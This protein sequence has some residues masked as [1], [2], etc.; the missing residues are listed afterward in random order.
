MFLDP[1]LWSD[2][3][4]STLKSSEKAQEL[5][6]QMIQVIEAT[7]SKNLIFSGKLANESEIEI[8]G[9]DRG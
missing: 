5:L 7:R 9:I 2:N 4:K 1:V 8:L 6:K 3:Y